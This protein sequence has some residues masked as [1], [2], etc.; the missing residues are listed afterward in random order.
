MCTV[1]LLCGMVK[2]MIC[3]SLTEKN[4]FIDRNGYGRFFN[5]SWCPKE[6][7]SHPYFGYPRVNNDIGWLG[8]THVYR[9]FIADPIFFEKSVKGTIEHGSNN[10]LTLDLATV[11]IGIRIQQYLFLQL[12]RKPRGHRSLSSITWTY[13]VGVT[14]GVKLRVIKQL[15]GEMNK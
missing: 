2:G 11:A 5:T 9:F 4:T 6:A 7:F 15:F 13:I 8:R 10:N 1:L 12:L 14:L 3:G